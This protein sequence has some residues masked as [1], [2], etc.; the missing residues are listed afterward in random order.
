MSVDH[1]VQLLWEAT[2]GMDEF[3]RRCREG[4]KGAPYNYKATKIYQGVEE[5]RAAPPP[6]PP[7]P[8]SDQL[9]PYR[10][11]LIMGQDPLD[12]LQAPAY[13]RVLFTADPAY[14]GWAT[15]SAA[16]ALRTAG[17][18]VGVWYVPTEV[19]K[20]RADDMAARLGTS[21]IIGQCETADQFDAS[22]AHGR[23]AMV[24]NLSALRSDQLA[25]V[26]YSERIVIPELYRNC[27][28]N[29]QPDWKNANA[30]IPGNCIAVYGDGDC[31]RMPLAQYIADGMFV[32][33]HDSVYGPQMLAADWAVLT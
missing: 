5:I 24:G 10:S 9:A 31:Q 32:A 21:F 30:G 18:G 22:V 17:H 33:H 3:V 20:A 25:K 13:Y 6:P 28:G 23:K 4:W 29:Q 26:A 11:L 15:E 1:G 7:P 27:N 14:D 19:S 16:N 12:A 8:P 2:I